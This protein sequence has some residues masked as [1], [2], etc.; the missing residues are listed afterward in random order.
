M[1][2]DRSSDVHRDPSRLNDEAGI[3]LGADTAED[4]D[5]SRHAQLADEARPR[6]AGRSKRPTGDL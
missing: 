5:T 3:S 6:S 4:L 2:P 1:P